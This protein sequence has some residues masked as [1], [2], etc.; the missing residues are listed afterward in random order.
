MSLLLGKSKRS[1][2]ADSDESSMALELD[3]SDPCKKSSVYGW[4]IF[5]S[6]YS[7]WLLPVTGEPATPSS[8]S[9]VMPEAD[10]YFVHVDA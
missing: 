5:H 2:N 6:L 1:C 7:C 4:P 3:V 8:N 9:V 10:P